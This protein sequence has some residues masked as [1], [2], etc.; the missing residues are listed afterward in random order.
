MKKLASI[1]AIA[2]I[3]FMASCNKNGGEEPI[4]VPQPERLPIQL[5]ATRATGSSFEAADQVGVYVVNQ[6]DGISGTLAVSGNYVDN[7]CFTYNDGKWSPE[8]EIYWKDR[9]TKADFYCYYPYATPTSV[10]AHTFE[11]LTDQST[12]DNYKASELIWGK[13][14][15]ATPSEEAVSITVNHSLSNAI[16]TVV[17]GTGFTAE[18][19]AVSDIQVKIA[20]VKTTASINLSNGTVSATGIASSVTMYKD[21]DLNYRALIVPQTVEEGALV[22]ITIDG[23]TYTLTKGFTFKSNTQHKFT[24]TVNKLNSGISIGIGDWVIDNVDNGGSAE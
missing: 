9:E 10:T 2:S 7:M 20:N 8:T 5:G 11:T 3:A 23:V 18:T 17:P 14:M 4:P 13:V 21:S 12:Y 6:T 15:G 16:V 22:L 19:L 24:V 1:F